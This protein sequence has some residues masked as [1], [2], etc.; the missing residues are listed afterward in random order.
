MIEKANSTASVCVLNSI[1]PSSSLGATRRG[2][3][4]F[5]ARIGGHESGD[6][7]S[8]I[9]ET[10]NVSP[11]YP[12][13]PLICTTDWGLDSVK[14]YDVVTV[15]DGAG[16]AEVYPAADVNYYLFGLIMNLCHDYRATYWWAPTF[17]WSL[18]VTEALATA[19]RSVT[20]QMDGA[21]ISTAVAFAE[22]GW[23][24]NWNVINGLG[25]KGAV[26]CPTPYQGRLEWKVGAHSVPGET[27]LVG[28]ID[29]LQG[30]QWGDWTN[31]NPGGQ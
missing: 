1:V 9:S 24:G 16:N 18:G 17:Q 21:G 15:V 26:P 30:P 5:S 20:S 27:D 31:L 23:T 2:G 12:S 3:A 4:T 29:G 8:V 28:I 14:P 6:T 19:N 11:D 22:A 25:M 13:L 7:I 10:S